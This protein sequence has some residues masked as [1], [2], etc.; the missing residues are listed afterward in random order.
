MNINN[1]TSYWDG[2]AELKTFTHPID[3]AMLGRYINKQS[4]ILDFGCGYGRIVKELSESGFTSVTGYD[5]SKE[6]I[7]R[8]IRENNSA[9]FHIDNPLELPV[10]EN[11][12][13]CIL[14]FAVLTCIPSNTGQ[15]ALLKMLHSKLK[16][17]GILY[18]SDYYLQEYSLE[19]D[20]YKYL[21][22]DPKNFGVFSLPEG[23]IFRHHSKEWI[24]ELTKDFNIL[25][26]KPIEVMTMNGHLAKGFQLI[27][28]K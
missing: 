27:L 16:A 14:L 23:A 18:I 6:L 19:V 13:D 11:S 21:N 24:S 28:Q 26:E 3:I 2:V 17:N 12:I 1:Q 22:G 8:G 9:L 15:M 10:R 7:N 25:I 4:E 5:T 20:R